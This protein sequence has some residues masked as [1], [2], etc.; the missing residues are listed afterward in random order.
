VV[1][2]GSAADLSVVASVG[3]SADDVD[4]GSLSSLAAASELVL[5]V[6]SADGASSTSIDSPSFDDEST[7]GSL[8]SLSLSVGVATVLAGLSVES[9]EEAGCFSSCVEAVIAGLVDGETPFCLA[10]SAE[11]TAEGSSEG[12][13][14]M[15]VM[16]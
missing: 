7:L 10:T 2:D 6:E 13:F 14:I 11:E 5:A 3:L 16:G 9:V 4:E 8:V 15:S 1:V 12:F